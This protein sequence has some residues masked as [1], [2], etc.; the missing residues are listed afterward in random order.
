M[1]FLPVIFAFLVCANADDLVPNR[2]YVGNIRSIVENATL[3]TVEG[4]LSLDLDFDG[5]G[6]TAYQI[7]CG[8]A[9]CDN[10]MFKQVA[11]GKCLYIGNAF[12][13]RDAICIKKDPHKRFGA[14][15]A[16]LHMDSKEG[17][18]VAYAYRGRGYL[19][20]ALGRMG[21]A[22]FS[23]EFCRE[24]GLH[25]HKLGIQRPRPL[26]GLEDGDDVAGAHP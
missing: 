13:H 12:F 2:I 5:K 9:G 7:T 26:D 4:E 22:R 16:Y 19:K 8:N 18:V 21:Y 25:H 11:P 24:P 23:S 1:R 10:Y 17:E 15:F 6:E 3:E 20:N 14:L